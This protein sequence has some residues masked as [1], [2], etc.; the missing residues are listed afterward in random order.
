MPPTPA[1]P[2][3]V[4]PLAIWK[5]GA[6]LGAIV[7]D[8]NIRKDAAV[9]IKADNVTIE[10]ITQ[11]G[12]AKGVQFD[13]VKNFRLKYLDCS[14]GK[15]R[16][17]GEYSGGAKPAE[18]CTIE[19]CFIVVG[20][21]PDPASN[22]DDGEHGGRNHNAIN[23][24]I[25]HPTRSLDV[26][27]EHPGHGFAG[28]IVVNSAYSGAAIANKEGSGFVAQRIKFGHDGDGGPV[29]NGPLRV[30]LDDTSRPPAQRGG[31]RTINPKYIGCEINVG[32]RY[33]TLDA[34]TVDAEV[35][36]STINAKGGAC[37][38]VEGERVSKDKTQKLPAATGTFT[39]V[40]FIG[41]RLA[42]DKT[43]PNLGNL[44]FV[45]CTFTDEATGKTF[46]LGLHGERMMPPIVEPHAPDLLAQAEQQLNVFDVGGSIRSLINYLRAKR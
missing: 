7:C 15:P 10:S 11:L 42:S 6:Q 16:D 39:H 18:N 1:P 28:Y 46:V 30:H 43:V 38:D 44:K 24:T 22:D 14:N 36:D 37:L 21:G 25:G 45:E 35:T 4:T 26:S 17:Y 27:P 13:G 2:V 20:E 9:S 34:G 40:H 32:K 29:G 5:Q 8:V 19:T 12:I 23:L 3:N 41:E 31:E 33:F